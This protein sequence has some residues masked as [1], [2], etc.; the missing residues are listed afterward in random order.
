MNPTV[1]RTIFGVLFLAVMLGGLLFHRIAFFIL[2]SFIS[3]V[4]LSEFYRMTMGNSYRVLQ[5]FASCMGAALVWLTGSSVFRGEP[6]SEALLP[7]LFILL[8]VEILCCQFF[9]KTRIVLVA[10]GTHLHKFAMKV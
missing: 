5:D 8:H 9:Y 1:K 7:S 3:F 10:A 6:L 2:F 4:M